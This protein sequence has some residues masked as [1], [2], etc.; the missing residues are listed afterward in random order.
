[1]AMSDRILVGI[2][3]YAASDKSDPFTF[4]RCMSHYRFGLCGTIT[5][6]A[7]MKC[8]GEGRKMD[9]IT[10][11]EVGADGHYQADPVQ[12]GRVTAYRNVQRI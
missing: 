4:D 10:G 11:P 12:E 8:Q 6:R 5:E 9:T 7:D 2:K 1:M 3:N